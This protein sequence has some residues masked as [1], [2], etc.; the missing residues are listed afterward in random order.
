MVFH[1]AYVG[2]YDL[3]CE[4][5]S[6][7]RGGLAW[8]VHFQQKPDLP[9]RLRSYR[10]NG[11]SYPIALRGRAWILRDTFQIEGLETNLVS[12][13]PKIRLRAEHITV[14]YAPV[15]FLSHHAELWL[16][17]SAE[18]YFDFRGRRM[19]RRHEFCD[20]MLFSVDEEQQISLPI[21]EPSIAADVP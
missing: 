3:I 9:A 18:V 12:P 13:V 7:R 17:E 2:D 21:I 10:V 11:T 16:P 5:L 4:G 15:H 14:E 6:R 1:P 8:Q 19:H 20:Y